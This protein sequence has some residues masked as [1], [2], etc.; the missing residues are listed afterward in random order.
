MDG[1]QSPSRAEKRVRVG[2]SGDWKC[3]YAVLSNKRRLR[4]D[5]KGKGEDVL[6]R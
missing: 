5:G 3:N 2:W 6:V 4:E 1:L